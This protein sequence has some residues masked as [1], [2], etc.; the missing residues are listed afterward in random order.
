MDI[1]LNLSLE[2]RFNLKIYEDQVKN[3]SPEESQQFLLEV[4]RQL[5]LKD[6][7]VKH[8]LKEQTAG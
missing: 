3:L 1:P 5:M 4:L 8:L 6:N 7:M 2:Q